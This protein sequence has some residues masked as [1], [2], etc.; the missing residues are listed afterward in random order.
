M[1]CVLV[2]VRILILGCDRWGT[3]SGAN[4]IPWNHTVTQSDVSTT[5]VNSTFCFDISYSIL[6]A[7]T[8]LLWG[9]KTLHDTLRYLIYA[10][11][12]FYWVFIHTIGIVIIDAEEDILGSLLRDTARICAR[13]NRI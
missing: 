1:L 10:R 12:V 6:P 4:G 5:C 13:I 11:H 2:V 8:N 9:R 7:A 3:V